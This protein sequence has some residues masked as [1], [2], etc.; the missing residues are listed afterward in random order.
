MSGTPGA[1]GRVFTLAAALI[2]DSAGRALLVRKQGTVA[3][4]QPGGKIEPGETARQAIVR[5]LE[6]ELTL[7]VAPDALGYLGRFEAP[8]ANE[9]GWLIDCEVFVMTTDAPVAAA[10][11]IAELR[12][13]DPA[14]TGDAIIA[15]L[16]V[17][18]VF[19]AIP[20]P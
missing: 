1:E 14:D 13:F 18:H 16:T 6:E 15:P 20:A 3:F 19:P 11:E 7:T 17:V 8:A 9:P 5:E 12:W 10:A 2:L 4:M